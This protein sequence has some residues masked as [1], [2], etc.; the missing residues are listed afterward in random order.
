M[1]L[2]DGL[3]AI[4]VGGKIGYASAI[5]KLVIPP[6]FDHANGFHDGVAWAANKRRGGFIDKTGRYVT[7]QTYG[8][9]YDYNMVDGIIDVRDAPDSGLTFFVDPTGREYLSPDTRAWFAK[10]PKK[11]P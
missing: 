6:R 7:K 8:A 3:I 4:E 11:E 5:G 9:L 1:E 2:S 10:Q